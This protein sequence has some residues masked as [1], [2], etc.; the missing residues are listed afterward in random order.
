MTGALRGTLEGHSD[1][2][3]KIAFSPNGQLLASG[4]FNTTI[5]LWDPIT[6]DLQGTLKGHPKWVVAVAFSPDGQLLA[7]ASDDLT[8]RLWL[9]EHKSLVLRIEHSCRGS[10]H[11]SRDGSQ[12]ILDGKRFQ[13]PLA[14]SPSSFQ[15]RTLADI[16]SPLVTVDYYWV[17]WNNRNVLWLP[18]NHRPNVYAMTNNTLA[19]GSQ[20]GRV[21]ILTFSNT[22]PPF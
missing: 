11:F 2:V 14:P 4:S 9:I 6:G 15:E 19:M 8:V 5:R 16:I 12:L 17:A 1:C 10:I 18:F 3:Y 20:S 21:T 22:I 7:S 13:I